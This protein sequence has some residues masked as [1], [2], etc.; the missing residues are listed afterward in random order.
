M[1]AAIVAHDTRKQEDAIR[2]NRQHVNQCVKEYSYTE[3]KCII[4]DACEDAHPMSIDLR[5]SKRRLMF[6][7]Q[8]SNRVERDN[9]YVV[10]SQPVSYSSIF[11]RSE[12]ALWSQSFQS[13]ALS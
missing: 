10:W 9:T 5:F 8:V 11:S 2:M 1:E 7:A 4:I 12:L 6:D 3:F 13:L